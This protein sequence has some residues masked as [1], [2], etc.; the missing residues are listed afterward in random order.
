M[1]TYTSHKTKDDAVD[2]VDHVISD[3]VIRYQQGQYMNGSTDPL[4]DAY[5]KAIDLAVWLRQAILN[6]DNIGNTE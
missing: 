4:W 5:E 6:K 1:Y 2:A 3:L